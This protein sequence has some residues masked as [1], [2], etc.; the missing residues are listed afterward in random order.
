[1]SAPPAE[2]AGRK[3]I[4]ARDLELRRGLRAR[5]AADAELREMVRDD[6]GLLEQRRDEAVAARRGA[7]RIRRRRRY[8]GRYVCIVSFTSTPRSHA[9]PLAFASATFGRMPTAITTRSAGSSV[10]SAKRTPCT[11]PSPTI[12]AV[13]AGIWNLS[14]R[15]S[16][17]RAQQPAGGRCRA[18]APSASARGARP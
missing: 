1:M 7:A 16:S 11:R 12:A 14:P 10:P 6:L 4:D 2:V 17:E 3:Q 13:C 5:V 9:M 18:G 15:C 8:A